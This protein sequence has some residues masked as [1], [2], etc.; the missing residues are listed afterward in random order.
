[1]EYL[2]GNMYELELGV[3]NLIWPC[4]VSGQGIVRCKCGIASWKYVTVSV[5][6]L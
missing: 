4:G 1:M 5:G 3:F 6:R 2:D